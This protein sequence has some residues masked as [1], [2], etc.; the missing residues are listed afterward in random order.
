MTPPGTEATG[1]A[2]VT[3]A[4]PGGGPPVLS[5]VTLLAG[6]G[7]VLAVIGPSGSGKSTALRAVAGLVPVTG[8]DVFVGGRPV[9]DVPVHERGLA[10]VFESAALVPFLDVAGNMTAGMRLRHRPEREI[11]DR[12]AERSRRLGLRALLHR[13]PAGLS[14]GERGLVGIGRATIEVPAAYLFDEPLAHLDP[15]GRVRTRRS[16][17]EVVRSAGAA[18]L[19]VTHDQADA[20]AIGDRVAVLCR[21]SV[22]QTGTGRELYERPSDLFVAGFVGS[23]PMGLV[24]GRVVESGGL[25]G[26]AVHSRT[27]PLW[28]PVPDVL[29][30]RIG[31]EVVLG[32]RPEDVREAGGAHT[33][34][35]EATVVTVEHLGPATSLGLVVDAPAVSAPGADPPAGPRARL[36]AIFPAHS[37]VRVGDR[38]RVAVDAT[39]AHVFDPV[40]GRALWHPPADRL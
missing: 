3:V 5:D 7:E 39:R 17:A 16:I 11:G 6:A 8:G 23:P 19:F 4:V 12:L 20:L 37:P 29:R 14:A 28:A 15:P 22:V 27:L 24:A 30:G 32:L 35:V 26:F 21:G 13:R 9:R 25:A 40:S 33:V 10:M 38:V 31:S 34:G 36:G 18:A 2:G 1:L